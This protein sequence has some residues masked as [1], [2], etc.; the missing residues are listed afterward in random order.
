V[1]RFSANEPDYHQRVIRHL[2][3]FPDMLKARPGLETFVGG[4]EIDLHDAGR[5]GGNGCA[6]L[7]PQ[8]LAG[9]Q[10]G[11]ELVSE[12]TEKIAFC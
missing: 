1:D 8:L 2:A 6:G 12:I 9:Q 3:T 7:L 4:N 11:R 10:T 5:G